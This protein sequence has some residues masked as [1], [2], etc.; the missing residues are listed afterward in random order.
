VSGAVWFEEDRACEQPY[1]LALPPAHAHETFY[2]GP[3]RTK[4]EVLLR[5]L[6]PRGAGES[7]R[8]ELFAL[9][10]LDAHLVHEVPVATWFLGAA[11]LPLTDEAR[12]PAGVIIEPLEIFTYLVTHAHPCPPAAR[13][14]SRLVRQPWPAKPASQPAQLP[15]KA[16]PPESGAPPSPAAPPAPPGAP[17]QDVPAPEA[18]APALAPLPEGEALLEGLHAAW[19]ALMALRGTCELA[20]L[21]CEVEAE[22]GAGPGALLASEE[23]RRTLEAAWPRLAALAVEGTSASAAEVERLAR[24]LQVR[25]VL[26]RLEGQ[27]ATLAR[28]EDRRQALS[29][30]L[31]LPDALLPEAVRRAG[32]ARLDG[33]GGGDT[34]AGWVRLLGR[35]GLLR[36][37][38]QRLLRYAPGD[39]AYTLNLM[40]GEKRVHTERFRLRA[41]W[42]EGKRRGVDRHEGKS[43]SRGA[44]FDL[45][46]AFEH[47]IGNGTLER[48]FSKLTETY[49]ANGLSLTVDG[50]ST[51][52][53]KPDES[54]TRVGGDF[55]TRSVNLATRQLDKHVEWM[56]EQRLVQE[57]ERVES[58]VHDNRRSASREVGIYHWLNKVY[59]LSVAERGTRLVIEFLVADPAAPL[60]ARL[61]LPPPPPPPD[62]LF[63]GLAPAR[64]DVQAATAL[65]TLYGVEEVAP[66]PEADAGTSD[67][68][69]AALREAWGRRTYEALLEGYWLCLGGWRERC[70]RR[71]RELPQGPRELEQEALKAGCLPLLLALA[72]PGADA[73]ELQR[74]FDVSLEWR[75]MAYRFYPWGTGSKPAGPAYDWVGEANVGPD[76]D[77]LFRRF[78][79]AGS[80]RVLVPV[81]PAWWSQVL[82]HF[83]FGGLPPWVGPVL[84]PEALVALLTELLEGRGHRE[85]APWTVEVPTALLYLQEGSGLP[86]Q[87]R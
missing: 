48:D 69:R 54:L 72:P 52:T 26:A 46:M 30:P 39:I 86:G 6:A 47:L 64:L 73:P 55:V 24:A 60:Y 59:A 83:Y 68:V 58:S 78:L 66:P 31:V 23:V 18:P 45:G 79:T 16:S 74:F 65:A 1:A 43:R 38:R 12:P 84:I 62:A 29:A 11:P 41:E 4:V 28:E 27:D 10:Q 35:P 20:A 49:G 70:E 87:P 51:E 80:A 56:R 75:D 3:H 53:A 63:P 50:S 8:A 42:A 37:L 17:P 5:K 36:T 81:A 15:P 57:A 19:R 71:L 82:H 67:A 77:T 61:G 34:N 76:A 14:A 2:V 21:A 33:T 44:E 85:D 7:A 25:D 40:P 32:A 13:A 9:I 22:V